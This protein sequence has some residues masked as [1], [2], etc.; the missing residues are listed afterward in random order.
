MDWQNKGP[1]LRAYVHKSRSLALFL[2]CKLYEG[3]F[4]YLQRVFPL[5]NS[6]MKIQ[7]TLEIMQETYKAWPPW[8]KNSN[9][10]WSFRSTEEKT[11]TSD[12]D[13]NLAAVEDWY[14]FF[15]QWSWQTQKRRRDFRDVCD[16]AEKE[17]KLSPILFLLLLLL[18]RRLFP[19]S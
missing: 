17:M 16:V 15:R 5:F 12:S 8:R 2:R 6:S 14:S 9:V 13:G 11:R 18:R 3:T 10:Y 19:Q 7:K 4:L 1:K